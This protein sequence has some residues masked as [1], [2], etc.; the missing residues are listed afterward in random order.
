MTK[1]LTVFTPTYNRAYCLER[2]YKSLRDQSCKSFEWLIVDDGSS[3]NTKEMVEK[4]T[5]EKILNIR[6]IY[7]KNAGKSMAHNEGVRQTQTELFLCVD[8]DDMLTPDAVE[9]ILNEWKVATDKNTGILM[10]K[11]DGSHCLEVTTIPE[12]LKESTLYDSY[13][14]YGLR[15]DTALVLRS[16]VIKQFE[17][18]KFEGENFVPE[19]YLYDLIDTKG[20]L[21]FVDKP[22]YNCEYLNDGYTKNM[23]KLLKNNPQGYTAYIL[24]R[25]H[26]L[27]K[28]AKMKFVD[29]ARYVAMMLT[30][31]RK[32]I[33]SKAV[34]PFYTLLA[35]PLG[36]ML[37]V[38]KYKN[39]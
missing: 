39:I 14:K 6:Y 37:Y 30:Y 24:Q 22:I 31:D 36:Y 13:N 10:R 15:G 21:R 3:D 29:S 1:L 34:Y 19:A 9:A 16:S 23:M 38:K 32:H 8:S 18:P 28:T 25:L 2:L 20:K 5:A 17:F 27:D 12:G 11:F 26:L 7:Q 35:L 33:F 4:W